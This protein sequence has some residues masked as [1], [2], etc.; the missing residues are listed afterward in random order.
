MNQ[1][2]HGLIDN[3]IRH[4]KDVYKH[5]YKELEA[6]EDIDQR[7]DRFT[8]HNVIE[9]LFNLTQTSIIQNAWATRQAPYVHGWVYDIK[10]GFIK[11]LDIS[12]NDNS[13]L[14][15]VYKLETS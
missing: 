10:T 7:Q 15:D 4:I 1:K 5:H 12:M 8:E 3:W 6:I 14:H 11:D 2:Q 13:R 9:Q